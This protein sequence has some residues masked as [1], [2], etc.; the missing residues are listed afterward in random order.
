MY[1]SKYE[2][3][4]LGLRLGVISAMMDVGQNFRFK[5]GEHG[6]DSSRGVV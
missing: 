4:T 1:E 6:S 5:V 3:V 2:A